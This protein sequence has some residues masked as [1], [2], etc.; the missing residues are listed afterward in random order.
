MKY[1][2]QES[3]NTVGTTCATMKKKQLKCHIGRAKLS[4]E[5]HKEVLP[6]RPKY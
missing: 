3:T 1:L 5:E 2:A 4:P 6:A